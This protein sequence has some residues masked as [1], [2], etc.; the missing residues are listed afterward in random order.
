MMFFK[1]EFDPTIINE[2]VTRE[3]MQN[4]C[5]NHNIF[6]HIYDTPTFWAGFANFYG[7]NHGLTFVEASSFAHMVSLF[8]G[9]MGISCGTEAYFREENIEMAILEKLND[10]RNKENDEMKIAT[11]LFDDIFKIY[12]DDIEKYSFKIHM[13]SFRLSQSDFDK[14]NAVEGDSKISKLRELLDNYFN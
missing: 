10:L 6:I 3:S 1:E 12:R 4:W 9:G 7:Q 11:M 8:I 2:H 14:F 5:D 13:L